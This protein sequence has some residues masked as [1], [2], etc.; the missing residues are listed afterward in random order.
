MAN[1]VENPY[2][3]DKVADA[4]FVGRERLLATLCAAVRSERNAIRAVIGGRGMGKSSL[5]AQLKVRLGAD[6]L[7]VVAS[8]TAQRIAREIGEALGVAVAVD[9]PVEA[10]VTAARKGRVALVLDEIEKV[11]GDP[12]GIGFL[13]N[14]REAYVLAGGRLALIVLGGTAVYEL[15]V[16][17]ASPFLR[18]AGGIHT[19]GGLE[20]DEAAELLRV[21]LDLEIS[22]DVVD[23]LWTDTSG[24]PWLLQM[25][26]EH[27]VDGA[28][29]HAEIVAHIPAAIREASRSCARSRFRSGGTTSKLG[30]RISIAAWC[31][32]PLRSP[33]AGG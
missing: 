32:S 19:L 9:T 27:A 8:G 5:A 3:T 31:A 22:D 29:S 6:A 21:P 30:D 13:D 25:F 26:M 2:R 4:L 33:A 7:T 1:G 12:A 14:L 23:A 17:Q 16:D 20:R 11:R 10:L 24:H 28:P 15:L 18:I